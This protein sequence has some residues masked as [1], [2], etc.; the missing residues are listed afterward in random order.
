MQPTLHELFAKQH[1]TSSLEEQD[2]KDAEQSVKADDSD[3]EQK[4][5]TPPPTEGR[6]FIR[7]PPRKER[8]EKCTL[9][10]L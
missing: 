7:I 1:K 3:S 6:L 8:L 5:L 2:P 10:I 4:A 9:C